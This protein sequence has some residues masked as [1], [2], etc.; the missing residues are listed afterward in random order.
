[1]HLIVEL[2]E[3]CLK[4]TYVSYKGR[5]FIQ[6]RGCAMGSLVSPIIVDLYMRERPWHLS[7]DRHLE[8]GYVTLMTPLLSSKNKYSNLSLNT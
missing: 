2:L 1:M 8:C 6:K 3:L 5:Y 7:L 4:T